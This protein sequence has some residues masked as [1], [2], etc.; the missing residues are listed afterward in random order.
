MGTL[1]IL[2]TVLGGIVCIAIGFPFGIAYRKR[3]SEREIG[4]AET[5]AT[6]IINEAMD[7]GYCVDDTNI[8]MEKIGARPLNKS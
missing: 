2:L 7:I 8:A 5:E 1:E 4:S 6:R 3:V